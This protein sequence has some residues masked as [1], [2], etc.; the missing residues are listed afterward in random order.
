MEMNKIILLGQEKEYLL[1]RKKVKNINLRIKVDGSIVVSAPWQVPQSRVENFLI[2]KSAY[3]IEHLERFEQM[4]INCPKPNEYIEGES[5]YLLGKRMR[6]KVHQEEKEDVFV[7]GEYLYLRTK[8][9]T[10]RRRKEKLVVRFFDK[11]RDEYF[12]EIVDMI[13]PIFKSYG[14]VYPVI[15]TRSMTSCWGVCRPTRNQITLNKK[16]IEVPRNCIEYV[17]L[18]EFV[19]FIHPNHSK[20]FYQLLSEIMPDWKERKKNLEVFVNLEQN[21]R[22]E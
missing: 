19:H 15:K 8:D 16:L 2:S 6:L 12:I 17:V 22:L 10:N 5:F 21:R 1:L 4:Q 18:H 3:I 13:F 14:V 7:D 9:I 20:A 11:M